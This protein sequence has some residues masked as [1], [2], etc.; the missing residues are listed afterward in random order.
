MPSPFPVWKFFDVGIIP[1]AGLTGPFSVMLFPIALLRW[2]LCPGKLR[3][4]VILA[5]G[6][7]S[8]IQ[9][10]A[11]FLSVGNQRTL[12]S[13]IGL[14]PEILT[15]IIG[16]QI[17]LSPLIGQRGCEKLLLNFPGGYSWIALL[18]TFIGIYLMLYALLKAPLELRLFIIF[19]SLIFS[20]SLAS[21]PSDVWQTLWIPVA[22]GRY[23]FIPR[24]VFVATL[25]WLLNR[26]SPHHVRGIAILFFSIMLIGITWDW[27][28]PHFIDFQFEYYANKFAELPPA[29][30]VKISINPPYCYMELIKH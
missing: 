29:S 30:K 8:L 22:G 16:G 21:I 3:I 1:L 15:R 10:L 18:V 9:G 6:I 27:Q 28:Q 4:P 2:W 17:F 24:L 25:V 5:L 26:L 20:S 11:I 7:A 19:G 12:G 23:W 13:F 14:T